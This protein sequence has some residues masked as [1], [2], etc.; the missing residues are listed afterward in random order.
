MF[1]LLAVV[2]LAAV[3]NGQQQ[4]CGGNLVGSSGDVFSPNYPDEYDANLDCMW[5]IPARGGSVTVAFKNFSI[6]APESFLFYARCNF[7]YVEIFVGDRSKGRFCGTDMPPA[8]TASKDV[9]IRFVTDQLISGPGF[10][11]S[12]AVQHE[13]TGDGPCGY[14]MEDNYGVVISPG[15]PDGYQS[16]MDC[17]WTIHGGGYPITLTFTDFELENGGYYSGCYDSVSIFTGREKFGTYCGTDTPPTLTTTK[18]VRIKMVTDSSLQRRGFMFHYRVAVPPGST[19]KPEPEK[20]TM[21]PE[22]SGEGS[23]DEFIF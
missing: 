4:R 19:E 3:A 16:F 11:F 6:E 22:G 23:G 12:Y 2:C 10:R 5:T 7:D 15:Y 13:L 17:T 14:H 21:K 8:I 1:A 20:T 9:H 18:D